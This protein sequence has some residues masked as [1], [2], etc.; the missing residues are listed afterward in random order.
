ML[1]VAV[2]IS[3]GLH[4]NHSQE[5]LPVF[6]RWRRENP[7]CWQTYYISAAIKAGNQDKSGAMAAAQEG[8]K[9][10]PYNQSFGACWQDAF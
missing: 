3:V 10:A 2:W 5:V 7:E 6:E 9:I 1:Y 4:Q 8:L